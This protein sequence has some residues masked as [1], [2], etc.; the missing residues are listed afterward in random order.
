MPPVGECFNG[1]KTDKALL[2]TPYLISL[3]LVAS[4]PLP[5]LPEPNLTTH[6]MGETEVASPLLRLCDVSVRVWNQI[7]TAQV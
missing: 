4:L 7:S 3:D 6:R 2:S 5:T 1:D